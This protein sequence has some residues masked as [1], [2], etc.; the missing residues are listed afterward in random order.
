MN[1][2][3]YQIERKRQP[4][5]NLFKN[6]V[7]VFS[8]KVE[9]VVLGEK[10]QDKCVYVCNHANKMGPFIFETYL[11]VYC[12]KWGASEMLS[13]YKERFKYLRDVLYMQKN[14][15]KKGKATLKATY[16]AIFS[17]YI[18]KG[19]KVLPTYRDARE[20][21]TIKKS[22]E[23][24]EKGV[25]IMI[26]PEDSSDGYFNEMKKFLAGFVLLMKAYNKKHGEDIPVRPVYYHKGKRLIVVG[27]EVY[28]SNYQN[29]N[30][31]REKIAEDVKNKVNQLYRDVEEGKIKKVAI[32]N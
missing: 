16:E 2:V 28:Y 12:A 8:K 17:K 24:L 14:H 18:Y 26:F 1:K 30:Y 29:V 7:K 27:E 21:S 20:I 32:K 6:I 15:Y 4:I 5:F 11:P 10:L 31:D 25:G 23:V 22:L 3:E 19:V 9:V 13:N